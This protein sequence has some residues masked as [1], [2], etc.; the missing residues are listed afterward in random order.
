MEISTC[1]S[2]GLL[3]LPSFCLYTLILDPKHVVLVGGF[4]ANDWLCN[5][6]HKV[7]KLLRIDIVRPENGVYVSAALHCL[8]CCLTFCAVTR[9]FLMAP[10][11]SILKILSNTE[12]ASLSRKRRKRKKQYCGMTANQEPNALFCLFMLPLTP[13]CPQNAHRARSHGFWVG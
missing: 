2:H 10:S 12:M 6:V 8:P 11:S 13:K 9:Q 7:F 3:S 5:E 4:A 1:E